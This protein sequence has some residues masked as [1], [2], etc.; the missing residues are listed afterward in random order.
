MTLRE[1]PGGPK[2]GRALSRLGEIQLLRGL[3]CMF[4]EGIRVAQ[5]DFPHINNSQLT[6]AVAVQN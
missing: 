1:A 6:A 3:H 4:E 5:P 2:A